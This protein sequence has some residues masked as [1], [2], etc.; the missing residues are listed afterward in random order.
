MMEL[1]KLYSNLAHSIENSVEAEAAHGKLY[2]C[3][4]EKAQSKEDF[5]K[6]EGLAVNM[7]AEYEKNGFMYGFKYAAALLM[8]DTSDT[9]VN[10][11]KPEQKQGAPDLEDVITE[12]MVSL[13]KAQMALDMLLQEYQFEYEPDAQKALKY[14][15]AVHAEKECTNEERF[16]YKYLRDYKK[17]MYLVQIASDYCYSA[18]ESCRCVYEGGTF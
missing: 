6:L 17:I 13:G 3:F 10:G 4:K 8:S 16:S 5:L 15:N 18:L 7:G 14:G 12:N 1:E 2:D 11:V 9:S